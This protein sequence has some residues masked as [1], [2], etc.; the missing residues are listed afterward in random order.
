MYPESL[1]RPVS[2]M[3][4]R[5]LELTIGDRC[6]FEREPWQE[7]FM[8]CFTPI[9]TFI[10]LIFLF[11]VHRLVLAHVRCCARYRL[12]LEPDQLE[13]ELKAARAKGCGAYVR[14]QTQRARDFLVRRFNSYGR[15]GAYRR[16]ALGFLVRSPFLRRFS[17][18]F[19]HL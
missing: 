1:S 9:F 7:I 18:P 3:S 14:Y 8:E 13:Q 10:Q 4:S 16:S 6:P 17:R 15:P 12:A 11:A 2:Y 19:C 5:L